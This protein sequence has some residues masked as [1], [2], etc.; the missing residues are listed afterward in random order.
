MPQGQEILTRGATRPVRTGVWTPGGFDGFPL[1][2]A[3]RQAEELG[4]QGVAAGRVPGDDQDRVV[5]RDRAEDGRPGGVVDGRGEELRRARPGVRSTTRLALASAEVSSSLRYLTRRDDPPPGRPGC[6][7]G[8]PGPSAAGRP[9]PGRLGW[10]TG[11]GAGGSAVPV[12]PDAAAAA[13]GPAR[14]ARHARRYGLP[15]YEGTDG[16]ES[17]RG[18]SEYSKAVPGWSRVAWQRVDQRAVCGAEPHDAELVQVAGQRRLRDVHAGVL[19]SRPASCSCEWTCSR[20]RIATI[21]ACL[22]AL[23][24]GTARRGWPWSPPWRVM[25]A[26]AARRAAPSARAAGSPPGPRPRWPGRRSPPR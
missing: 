10:P 15:V 11:T 4:G 19:P 23:V 1:T 7:G 12:R 22:A 5:P 9:A 20:E 8:C 14:L 18:R 16:S 25:S 21:R 24:A 13:R 3:F 17:G 6:P 26:P 2:A